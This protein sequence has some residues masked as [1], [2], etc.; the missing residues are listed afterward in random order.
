[1]RA[2]VRADEVGADVRPPRA[3]RRRLSARLLLPMAALACALGATHPVVAVE[4][5]AAGHAAAQLVTVVTRVHPEG[6]A[7]RSQA[8]AAHAA[9]LREGTSD[10]AHGPRIGDISPGGLPQ[11]PS[12]SGSGLPR[13]AIPGTQSQTPA[14]PS[15]DTTATT[16]APTVSTTTTRART[17][18]RTRVT[19]LRPRT[20][21]SARAAQ[22]A[23]SPTSALSVHVPDVLLI[24]PA[25]LPAPALLRPSAGGTG[26][27]PLVAG[28][29]CLLVLG[30]LL[31]LRLARRPG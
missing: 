14:A 18:L 13:I 12:T 9:A 26:I 10:G 27:A 28:V 25:L 8:G 19:A 31:G 11:P 16:P 30:G 20:A 15:G 5:G 21:A 1:M 6:A 2:L 24:P 17:T 3:A 4:A 23:P 7:H 22:A 29:M